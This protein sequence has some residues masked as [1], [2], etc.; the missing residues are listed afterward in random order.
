MLGDDQNLQ[1]VK[2][3]LIHAGGMRKLGVDGTKVKMFLS[4]LEKKNSH[5]DSY[6]IRDLMVSDLDQ[7]H[8]VHLPTVYTR[9]ETPVSKNEISTQEDVDKWPQVD[10][11]IRL[12][13]ASDILKALD[14]VEV[15]HS[16]MLQEHVWAGL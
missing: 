13:I 14:P 12:L 1:T 15:K 8:F 2:D 4:T 5:L 11:E 10:A 7:S 9:P 3:K 16:S 6:L